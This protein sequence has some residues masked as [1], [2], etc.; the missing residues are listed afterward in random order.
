MELALDRHDDGPEFARVNKILKERYGRPI[1][2]AADNPIL[3]T[4]MYEVEYADVYKT[5][6]TANAIESN[7]FT[8]FTKMD[9]VYYYSTPSYICLPTAHISRR[10]TILSIC[11]METRG[12]EIPQKDGKFAYNGKIGVL[13]GTKLRTSRSPS[14]YN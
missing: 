11:T 14:R 3:D 13:L 6:I 9:N 4:R 10:G 5:A 8:K 2:I 1:G 7:L 12:G